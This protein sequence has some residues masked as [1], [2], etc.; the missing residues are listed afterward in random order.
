MFNLNLNQF[1]LFFL[2]IFFISCRSKK[3]NIKN[4]KIIS[5]ENAIL[6]IT[7]NDDLVVDSDSDGVVN[8]FDLEKNTPTG[9]TVD[10][11]GRSLDLDNDGVPDYLDDDPFSTF[12]SFVDYNGRELDDD[13]DG[14]PNNIDLE[15]NT[16]NG[17]CVNSGGQSINCKDAFF[18]QIYFMPNSS[19]V[20]DFNFDRL[21]VIS[22]VLRKNIN[23]K[24]RILGFFDFE[25]SES[26]NIDLDLKRAEAVAN[27]LSNIFGID[28]NRMVIDINLKKEKNSHNLLRRVEFELF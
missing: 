8:K 1:L 5:I 15:L 14:I 18:P 22:S 9:N 19:Q 20:E 23:Y 27:V 6:K 24:V 11:S 26:Y 25:G 16:K 13:R 3:I 21:Q 17:T 2:I 10:E 12:G 28:L 4:D 7:K